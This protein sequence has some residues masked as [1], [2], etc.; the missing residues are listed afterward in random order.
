MGALILILVL[1]VGNVF[2]VELSRRPAPRPMP[3]PTTSTTPAHAPTAAT[4]P[5]SRPT[6]ATTQTPAP[7][8]TP[9]PAPTVPAYQP[10][11]TLWM[12]NAT[13]GWARATGQRI[14]HTID[15]GKHWQD[16]TPPYPADYT[17]NIP[18]AFAS[19]NQSVAWVAVFEKQQPNGTM[20]NVVFRTSDGGQNWQEAT[21]PAG[22]LGVSQVQFI[23]AQDGWLLASF[24]GSGAGSQAVVLYRSTD[25]GQTWSFVARAGYP[26]GTIPLVGFKSGMSWLSTSTGWITGAINAAQNFV[27]LYRTQD[28]GVTWQQ[29]S[30]PLPSG[31][32]VVTMYPPVFFSATEGL[33]PVTFNTPPQGVGLIVYATHDGGATWSSSTL[34]PNIGTTWNRDLLTMQQ[35]WVVAASGSTLDE[36]NDGGQHW[37]AITSGGNFQH[38]A[39]VDFVSVQEGWAISMA[40]PAA[41]LL[42]Q[43]MDG[44]QSWVQVSPTPPASSFR[45]TSV[46]L[47]VSPASISGRSCGTYLTVTYT[48]TFH[49]APNGPGGTIRFLYSV[50]NGRGSTSASITVAPAR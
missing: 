24:G 8:A 31:Q 7:A 16:V 10:I 4:T 12:S 50:N 20:P 46:S 6:A 25:G 32:A 39:Q 41:L 45:V 36:T 15:G 22:S 40:N 48:A 35:G 38:I 3:S 14:L 27:Y 30:L 9:T 34:L 13:S 33:L 1:I 28:G 2:A 19:L 23:N 44:G 37:T 26:G 5:T 49:L 17:G 21:L 18:P 11:N 29:Q 42:L 43:T 47:S